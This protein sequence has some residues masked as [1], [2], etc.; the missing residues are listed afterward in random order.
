MG[1]NFM[2]ECV[3]IAVHLVLQ[4][5][6]SFK[7][8]NYPRQRANF[9]RE[10][11]SPTTPPSPDHSSQSALRSSSQMLHSGHRLSRARASPF[12]PVPAPW[13]LSPYCTQIPFPKTAPP[14]SPF[15]MFLNSCTQKI[16]KGPL[17]APRRWWNEMSDYKC[18]SS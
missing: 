17:H 3:G 2:C 8:E 13:P 6:P 10:G 18:S 5:G 14:G 12:I 11:S 1:G 16:S 4:N 9:G 15:T 7:G